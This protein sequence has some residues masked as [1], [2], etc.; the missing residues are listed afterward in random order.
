MYKGGFGQ[1]WEP[2]AYITCER[3]QSP[4]SSENVFVCRIF[5]F[6]VKID[7][8]QNILSFNKQNGPWS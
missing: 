7:N 3:Y 1:G 8:V 4:H 6:L 2:R 5:L